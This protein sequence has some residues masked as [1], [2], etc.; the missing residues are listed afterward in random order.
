MGVIVPTT[1]YSPRKRFLTAAAKLP[2][3]YI[4]RDAH[5][6]TISHSFLAASILIVSC[7]QQ[8]PLTTVLDAANAM[9]I[10]AI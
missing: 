10:N 6:K 7:L 2:Q 9:Y 5:Q 8:R 4:R 1:S 3:T